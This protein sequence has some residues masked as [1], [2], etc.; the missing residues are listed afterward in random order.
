MDN[1]TYDGILE[2]WKVQ[3]IARRARRLGI[4][5]HQVPDVLQELSLTLKGFRFDPDHTRGAV[6]STA[7]TQVIDNRIRKIKRFETRYQNCLDRLR[8]RHARLEPDYIDLLAMDVGFVVARL[9]EP[10]QAVCACLAGGL[11]VRATAHELGWG[12]HTVKRIVRELR[13]FFR[14]IGLEGWISE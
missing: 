10:Q 3:L 6:E 5:A 7:L 9:S 4:P 8:E 14:A 1:P 2:P 11:S 13:D 12:H